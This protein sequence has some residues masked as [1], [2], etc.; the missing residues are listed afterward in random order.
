MTHPL[1]PF[2]Q[3]RQP[4]LLFALFPIAS[5]LWTLYMGLTHYPL[6]PL[7]MGGLLLVYGAVLWWRPV[8]WLFLIPALLPLAN[9][10]LWTGWLFFEELDLFLAVTVVIGYIRLLPS[11]PSSRLSLLA[12]FFLGSL[13]LSYAISTLIG[14]LPLQPLDANAFSNYLSH[15]N[16]LRI[17]KP[18]LWS[19]LLLPL[20]SRMP[21]DTRIAHYFMPGLLTGLAGVILTALWERHLFTGLL[22][23]SSD[24]RIT[25]SFPEMHVG[26]AALDAFLSITL[27]FAMYWFLKKSQQSSFHFA[28][29]VLLL[30]G[31]LY[32]VLVTFSRGLYLGWVL[33]TLIIALSLGRHSLSRH[34]AIRSQGILLALYAL[35]GLLFV[36]NF[37]TGGYRGLIGALF[38]T[39]SALYTGGQQAAEKRG[40]PYLVWAAIL[41]VFSVSFWI[42]FDKGPYVAFSLSLVSVIFG[43]LLKGVSSRYSRLSTVLYWGGFLA[44]IPNDLAV[45]WHWGG[46]SAA[47]SG[48]AISLLTL[49]LVEI[50]SRLHVP[51]WYWDRQSAPFLLLLLL[52]ISI[53]VPIALNYYM[54]YR[55]NQSATDAHTREEHWFQSLAMMD[56]SGYGFLFGMGLGRYPENYFWKNKT[57]DLPGTYQ[58]ATGMNGPFLRIE[59]PKYKAGFGE[60]LRIG[61]WIFLKPFQSYTLALEARSPS[62]QA[63][64]TI[65]AC[66]KLVLFQSTNQCIIA[67]ANVPASTQWQQVNVHFDSS[68]MG[69]EPW[70]AR[71]P[72]QLSL[73]NDIA[74]TLVDITSV[75]LEAT[76]Q[77]QELL[78]NGHFMNGM[79]RWYFTSDHYHLPWHAK[80]MELHLFFEQGL[81]GLLS[82][83]GLL[84][85]ALARL[86]RKTSTGDPNSTLLLAS[87][88]GLLTVGLFDSV[89]DFPRLSLLVYLLLYLSLLRPWERRQDRIR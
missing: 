73:S 21:T 54:V 4:I 79:D 34:S 44:L 57:G 17:F 48:T 82:F 56:E 11:K 88:V 37:K 41:I 74:G 49:F 77:Q 55:F 2:R 27:P 5:C 24:Y 30:T 46:L 39:G 32:T 51:L 1:L 12:R 52:M 69:S 42:A 72:V 15:Y 67:I 29:G 35:L 28:A 18:F 68:R 16:S 7:L 25:A 14:L 64:L 66:E 87:L 61:Q 23:F 45:N 3:Y 63:R 71:P 75:S 53:P 47:L 84:F 65:E 85:L 80:N 86:T 50:N 43:G 83:S 36:I 10:S 60:S 33:S 40:V 76:D 78:K 13:M 8:L 58:L 22:D 70:Y 20:L 81:L 19:V 6:S 62:P 89:L 26:G 9:L 31:G 38:L 59:A